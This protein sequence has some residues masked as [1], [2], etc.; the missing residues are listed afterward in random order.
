MRNWHF[1][2]LYKNLATYYF[3]TFRSMFMDRGRS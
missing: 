3:L 1:T 2:L